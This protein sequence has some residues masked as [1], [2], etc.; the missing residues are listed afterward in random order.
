[1]LQ[2]QLSKCKRENERI[3]DALQESDE[4]K[5]HGLQQWKPHNTQLLVGLEETTKLF[6]KIKHID[7]DEVLEAHESHGHVVDQMQRDAAD[8][9][10]RHEIEHERLRQEFRA[11]KHQL[12]E[13]RDVKAMALSKNR[14]A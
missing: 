10:R 7:L 5:R 3:T 14:A 12:D 9:H 2:Q 11:L 1:M 4:N 13:E 6:E 8:D